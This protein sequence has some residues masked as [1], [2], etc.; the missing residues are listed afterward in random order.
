[1]DLVIYLAVTVILVFLV[2]L[3]FV[4]VLGPDDK[5]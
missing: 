1:M 3:F 2:A 4:V 5:P